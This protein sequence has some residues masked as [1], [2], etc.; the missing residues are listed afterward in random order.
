MIPL[1]IYQHALSLQRHVPPRRGG[2]VSID[3]VRRYIEQNELCTIRVETALSLKSSTLRGI[4]LRGNQ[5]GLTFSENRIILAGDLNYCW[6]RFVTLKELMHLLIDSSRDY[7]ANAA[8]LIMDLTVGSSVEAPALGS[9]L[10]ATLLATAYALPR[11][12]VP[13]SLSASN[14]AED[15]AKAFRVPVNWVH[16][17]YQR[18]A[19]DFARIDQSLSELSELA[20]PSP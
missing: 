13:P 16:V 18:L 9:E 4:L 14:M 12:F 19:P 6:R 15:V 17:Y 1:E 3:A 8:D 7:T 11:G 20:P 10:S 2:I 5:S